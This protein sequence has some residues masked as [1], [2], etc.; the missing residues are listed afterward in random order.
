[1]VIIP[2]II[3]GCIY[4]SIGYLTEKRDIYTLK[5]FALFILKWVAAIILSIGII[6]GINK[7]ISNNTYNL[8]NIIGFGVH[9]STDGENYNGTYMVYKNMRS[10]KYEAL[11]Q[12]LQGKKKMDN[13]YHDNKEN[14][15][16][17]NLYGQFYYNVNGLLN[18]EEN[19]IYLDNGYVYSVPDDFIDEYLNDDFIGGI[20]E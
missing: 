13:L 10:K 16:P 3:G 6:L 8:E 4:G 1:M 2:S 15:V 9:Y 5:K 20:Y 11:I 12:S 17:L 14:L 18:T 19:L 7:T